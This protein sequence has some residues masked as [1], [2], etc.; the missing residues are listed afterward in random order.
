LPNSHKSAD[1]RLDDGT[2]L[3]VKI[4]VNKTQL[5]GIRPWDF[6]YLIGIQLNND[7]EVVLAVRI[8]VGIYRHT[9]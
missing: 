8:P 7:A 9:A 6:D 5:G 3:Q 2:L 4:R 1:V